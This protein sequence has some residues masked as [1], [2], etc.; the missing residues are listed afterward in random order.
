MVKDEPRVIQA[1]FVSFRSIQG[2]KVLQLVLET[3][4][5]NTVEVM[6][7]LGAPNH[8]ESVSVAVALL[9]KELAT[10]GVSQSAHGTRNPEVEGATP[11]PAPKKK[12]SELKYSAQAGIRCAEPQF[13]EFMEIDGFGEEQAIKLAAQQVRDWCG[14][15]SRSELDDE[16]ATAER[17]AWHNLE[18]R[19]QSYLLDQRYGDR[20]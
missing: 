8:G 2:R 4:I 19:Y 5:T 10:D 9:N 16:S 12:F 11:S 14:I 17:E 13:W 20:R 6:T 7:K 15:I 1:D 3:D 18:S